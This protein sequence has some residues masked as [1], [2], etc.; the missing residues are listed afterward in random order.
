MEAKPDQRDKG[1]GEGQ[2][3]EAA[4]EGVSSGSLRC[5]AEP[6]E[7]EALTRRPNL[8][9]EPP[10]SGKPKSIG[11]GWAYRRRRRHEALCP[12]LE[13]PLGFR[14]RAVVIEDERTR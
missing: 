10:A 3:T 1:A 11:A 6:S 14:H 4:R 2:G 8:E 12:Y 5:N 13:R 7:S 9:G